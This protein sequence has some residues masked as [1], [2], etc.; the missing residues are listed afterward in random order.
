M[1][2]LYLASV[3]CPG[4]YFT[5]LATFEHIVTGIENEKRQRTRR[6]A[7]MLC[8]WRESLVVSQHREAAEERRISVRVRILSLSERREILEKPR[9]ANM[10][11][12]RNVA[13]VIGPDPHQA[14]TTVALTPTASTFSV[15][16][17][18][19]VTFSE[20]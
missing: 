16:V 13:T 6:A 4:S 18:T 20:R 17:V 1:T 14:M 11:R 10:Q 12:R 5:Q 3:P 19:D 15:L 2:S 9:D 8:V 7:N